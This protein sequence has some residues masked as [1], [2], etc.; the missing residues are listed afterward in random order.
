[1][2]L[3]TSI[4]YIFTLPFI[5]RAALHYV[6]GESQGITIPLGAS[7][8]E[9]M[10]VTV[11]P[12]ACGMLVRAWK[13]E[14][15]QRWLPLVKQSATVALCIIFGMIVVDN[16]ETLRRSWGVVLAMVVGMNLTNLV[17]ALAL[18]WAGRLSRPE[19]IAI[20]VEHLIRQETT[21]IFVAVTLLGRT[22]MSLPMI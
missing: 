12:I 9:I 15:A 4:I 13:P 22:D 7:L 11:F 21:A 16:W 20:T 5:A 18:S 2:S 8:L 14:P 10:R 1:L 3:S 17:I 19:R 6:F